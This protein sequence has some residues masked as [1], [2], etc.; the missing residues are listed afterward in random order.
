MPGL[1]K[2]GYK[3]F[4]NDFTDVDFREELCHH[5]LTEY[6]KISGGG[7]RSRSRFIILAVYFDGI[8]VYEWLSFRASP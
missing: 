1:E 2:R 8:A 6:G 4:G 5:S 7:D 3:V